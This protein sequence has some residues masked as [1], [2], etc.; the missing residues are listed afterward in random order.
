VG[1]RAGPGSHKN[2]GGGGN[3]PVQADAA[4]GSFGAASDHRQAASKVSLLHRLRPKPYHNRRNP[5][6]VQPPPVLC[7]VSL[8]CIACS[9]NPTITAETL[10]KYGPLPY[11]T[12]LHRKPELI[13]YL[14]LPLLVIFI[15][16]TGLALLPLLLTP[17]S[18][19]LTPYSLLLPF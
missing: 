1:R 10:S 3:A 2:S 16:L 9:Q 14:E 7:K 13:I 18:L 19:L 4:S 15:T 5:I 6:Q 11:R 12:R 8:S 17:Y